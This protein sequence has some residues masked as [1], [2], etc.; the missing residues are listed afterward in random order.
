MFWWTLFCPVT[1]SKPPRLSQIS[2]NARRKVLPSG[3][4]NFPVWQ[5]SPGESHSTQ[6]WP[7]APLAWIDQSSNHFLP[8]QAGGAGG[9]KQRYLWMEEAK[10]RELGTIWNIKLRQEGEGRGGGTCEWI[11]HREWRAEPRPSLLIWTTSALELPLQRLPRR[12]FVWLLVWNQER[13]PNTS[14]FSQMWF[15]KTATPSKFAFLWQRAFQKA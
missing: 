14:S 12:C 3:L 1:R 11:W 2:G 4:H 15:S 9:A 8:W 7:P 10:K 5:V 13:P 6:S